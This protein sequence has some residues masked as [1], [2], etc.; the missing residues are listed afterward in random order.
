MIIDFR[1]ENFKCFK[2]TGTLEIAPI[3]VLVGPNNSGKSSL[4]KA[5]NIL[6]LTS[7]LEDSGI[8][9]RLMTREYDHGTYKDLV[10]KHEED[11]LISFSL[12]IK[13]NNRKSRFFLSEND[14]DFLVGTDI[15]FSIKYGYIKSKHEIYMDSLTLSDEKGVLIT[16][17]ESK[18]GNRRSVKVR[19]IPD[20]MNS[21]IA[22][23]IVKRGF[24][25]HFRPNHEVFDDFFEY[26]QKLSIIEDI[27]YS[28]QFYLKKIYHLGPLRMP[29]NRSYLFSGELNENIGSTGERALLN[30]AALSKRKIKKEENK[31]IKLINNALYKLGFISEFEYKRV[32][33]RHY[34]YWAKH[35]E[36]NL[37]ANLADTGFGASQILP[38][39]LLLFT[40]PKNSML[41]IEQPEIHL[42]PA[43]QAE[44]GSIF[45]E[46]VSENKKVILETHS[47]NLIVRLLTEVAK[48][49]ISY[50]DILF[51]YVLPESGEH[52]V[53]NIPINEKGEFLME[54]PKG[55]FEEGYW[56]SVK[57]S[58]ARAEN[59]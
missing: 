14:S 41:L 23:T 11:E 40:T 52:K 35:P 39:L 3:T 4:I 19:D 6:S 7:S 38:V 58:K 9:L 55:F 47:E 8:P 5:L 10:Y 46:A 32:G 48:K 36:S 18:Y 24:I 20:K 54:W 13:Y 34:E 51:Y 22:S 49:N 16:I 21:I 26:Y 43:G 59:N 53:I 12:K 31:E 15:L 28:I 56:E 30:Y 45:V 25:Y 33:D 1:L 57:L 44:L 27:M 42:H 2:D 50:E 29:P 37:S 17:R